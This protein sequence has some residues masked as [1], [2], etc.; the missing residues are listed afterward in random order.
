MSAQAETLSSQKGNVNKGTEMTTKGGS[1]TDETQIAQRIESWTK[2]L[3]AKDI[4][5][6]MSHY[7]QDIVV[8]DLA[9][10]LQYKGADVYRKNWADW[11]PSFQGPIGY[12][13]RE[14]S[15]TASGDVAFS[16]SLN[17]ITGLRTSGEKTDVWIR[18]TIGFR[19]VGGQWMIMHEHFSTPFYMD[20]SDKAALDLKP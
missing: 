12:E 2:A 17:R 9:P 3:R 15:I 11:L 7:A 6:L 14:L 4:D 10:P 8:F 1:L 13:I 19:K 5:A 18:A 16:R 20:G